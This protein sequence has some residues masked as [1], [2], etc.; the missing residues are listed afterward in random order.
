M[1]VEI[2][3]EQRHDEITGTFQSSNKKLGSKVRELTV[4][5]I[6]KL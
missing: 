4:K 1:D 5:Y 6:N 3:V 2:V